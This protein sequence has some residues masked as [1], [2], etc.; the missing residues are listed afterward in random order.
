MKLKILLAFLMLFILTTFALAQTPDPAPTAPIPSWAQGVVYVLTTLA[1]LITTG[2]L[3]YKK[4]MKDRDTNRVALGESTID[5]K[6]AKNV[7]EHRET[8]AALN[9]AMSA[10]QPGVLVALDPGVALQPGIPLAPPPGP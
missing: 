4:V 7:V 10:T 9:V 2:Y 6:V 5:S 1:G 3:T 8:N